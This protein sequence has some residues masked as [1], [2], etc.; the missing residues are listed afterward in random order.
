VARAAAPRPHEVVVYVL[1]GAGPDARDRI[2]AELAELR[3]PLEDR[4]AF[5]SAEDVARVIAGFHAVGATSVILQPTATDPD[6]SATIQLAAAARSAL[7][8]GATAA[9]SA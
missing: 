1:C 7:V 2:E 8:A 9:A 5:G 3:Q 6:V 4:G